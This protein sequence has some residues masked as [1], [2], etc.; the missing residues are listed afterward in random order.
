MLFCLKTDYPETKTWFLWKP[1][2]SNVCLRFFPLRKVPKSMRV[3][4][5]GYHLRD[6]RSSSMFDYLFDWFLLDLYSI[7]I[8][9]TSP[10]GTP[11]PTC[12]L[13]FWASNNSA[14]QFLEAMDNFCNTL[15]SMV[16]VCRFRLLCLF[17]QWEELFRDWS[18]LGGQKCDFGRHFGT[19]MRSWGWLWGSWGSLWRLLGIFSGG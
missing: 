2:F 14:D 10:W 4:Q 17:R 6:N 19:K 5:F 3:L 16:C 12:F 7:L 13:P 1:L 8:L 9:L 11:P 15:S 18:D